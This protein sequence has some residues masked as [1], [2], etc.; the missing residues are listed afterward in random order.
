MTWTWYVSIFFPGA[1]FGF[2]VRSTTL[3]SLETKAT[4]QH[5][6]LWLA[7]KV[8]VTSK[9]IGWDC[10]CLRESPFV[11]AS[12]LGACLEDAVW[13]PESHPTW[14]AFA[15]RNIT[16]SDTLLKVVTYWRQGL[17]MTETQSTQ[18]ISW[19][20]FLLTEYTTYQPQDSILYFCNI[21]NPI[22]ILC[23]DVG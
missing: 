21:H 17:A 22:S 8:D 10:R 12:L 13:L 1:P 4:F 2:L 23:F 11:H 18:P 19:P 5:P 20:R 14:R 3:S 7:K 15:Q 6:V 16:R 9:P